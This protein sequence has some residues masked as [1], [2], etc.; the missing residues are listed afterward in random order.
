M[1]G[2]RDFPNFVT[3]LFQICHFFGL[4][5]RLNV[6]SKFQFYNLVSYLLVFEQVV[7]TGS[8]SLCNLVEEC[9]ESITI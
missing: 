5:Y 9:S 8:K 2:D 4:N 3:F 6:K 1:A 7:N